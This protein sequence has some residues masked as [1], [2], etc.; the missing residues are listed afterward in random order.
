M[1]DRWGQARGVVQATSAFAGNKRQPPGGRATEHLLSGADAKFYSNASLRV[2]QPPGGRAGVDVKGRASGLRVT[3]DVG[4]NSTMKGIFTQPA[5]ATRRGSSSALR[6]SRTGTSG[7]GS[8]DLAA[9]SDTR[10]QRQLRMP[11]K[12]PCVNAELDHV[13]ELWKAQQSFVKEEEKGE[14]P[15]SLKI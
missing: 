7:R 8:L 15:C 2:S 4:G 3:Q 11:P 6:P 9:A 10:W 5:G 13:M 1:P 12:K 14:D